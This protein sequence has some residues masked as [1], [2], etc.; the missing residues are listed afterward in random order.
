M[1]RVR[2]ILSVQGTV[3]G[4]GFRPFVYRQAVALGLFGLV[5]NRPEGVRIEVEGEAEAVSDLTRSLWQAAPPLARLYRIDELSAEPQGSAGFHIVPS[6]FV[7]NVSTQLPVDAAPCAEC[8]QELFASVGRRAGYAFINC[9]NC[10]PRLSIVRSLPYDRTRTTMAD[11]ALCP[12]CLREY[13]DPTDRR[14]HA[15]PTA[16]PDCGP[17]LFWDGPASAESPLLAC[18]SA[19]R[20]GQIVAIKGV[21]GF[22]LACDA[23]DPS[24][25]QR[26]RDRKHRAAKPFA[27]LSPDLAVIAAHAELSPSERAS[28]LSP[29]RPIVLLRQRADSTLAPQVAPALREV[30]FMLP[31]SPLD[32]LLARAFGR[33]LV[34]TSGNLSEE[35]LAWENHEAQCRLRPLADGFL[36][37][38]R[39][40]AFRLDDSVVRIE[41]GAEQVLRRARGYAPEPIAL[42]APRPLLA[43]GADLKN[44]LC[45]AAGDFAVVSAHIGDL[46]HPD[47]RAAWRATLTG[48][49][50]LLGVTPTAVAC[51]LN[52]DYASTRLAE[53]LGLP[54]WPV[55]HHHAH[56]AA[57]LAE[58]GLHEP[59]VGVVFDG[60]GL[61]EDGAI[62]GG[63]ILIADRRHCRRA[64]HLRYVPLPG[65]DAAAREPWRMA[66]AYLLDIGESSERF[67]LLPGR[68]PAVELLTRAIHRRVGSPLT[69]SI[70]RLFDAVSA[71]GGLCRIG[72]FEG[73]AAMLLEA[74]SNDPGAA[75]YAYCITGRE[76]A[77]I[78]LRPALRALVHDL[79]EQ[80]P[81][82]EIGSRFH[83]TLAAAVAQVVGALSREHGLR[84]VVLTGGCFQNALLSAQ[85]KSLLEHSGLCVLRPTRFPPGD[86]GISL[87]QIAVA[88][89]RMPE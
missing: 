65:G 43:V 76:P 18:L 70:G 38:D 27:L 57:G 53:S 41:H 69:S 81:I 85:C 7:G 71:L 83:A 15:E 68:Q 50:T 9:T 48:L 11:F 28:L 55:Q 60:A 75:P 33:P 2:R 17:Q 44:T 80:R 59:V 58:H 19:L 24:A 12:A 73:Q 78:D 86:G 45:L 23:C 42:H 5:Q 29:R 26:L 6:D 52:P 61:G 3:Q 47:T 62:W 21:G 51:D 14:Y 1:T 63:E 64:A 77:Q 74:H 66:L 37:H 87:G 56:L 84:T 49:T 13:H 35:P 79:L 40:I 36:L 4:V 34:M 16:C 72:Q 89:A 54:L 22:H 46:H 31:A 30:G 10:G 88:A 82:A 25:V 67:A 32:Y 39:P 8:L 20:S